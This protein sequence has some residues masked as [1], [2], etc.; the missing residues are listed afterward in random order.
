[1]PIL[2]N[3]EPA[4]DLVYY[5]GFGVCT[6]F[7][8]L[9]KEEA[10]TQDPLYRPGLKVIMDARNAEI[11]VNLEEIR[12]VVKRIKRYTEKGR[13]I[14]MTAVISYSEYTESLIRTILLL[15]DDVPIQVAVFQSLQHAAKWLGLA[16]S[17]SQIEAISKELHHSY[18]MGSKERSKKIASLIRENHFFGACH[19]RPLPVR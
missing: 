15:I 19:L 14:E 12:E 11:D 5:A 2:F 1:M 16:N 13:E 18:R 8:Y 9:D 6:G 10:V 17:V 3:I 4:L 7:E